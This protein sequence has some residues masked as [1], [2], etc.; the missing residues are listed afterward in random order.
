MVV[1]GQLL[2]QD[3]SEFTGQSVQGKRFL[4]EM[5]ALVKDTMVR[6][7]VRCVTGHKQPLD[8]GM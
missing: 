5:Y 8:V 1:G 6:D 3:L 4:D 2:V 7:D